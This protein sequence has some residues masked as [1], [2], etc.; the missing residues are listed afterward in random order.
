MHSLARPTQGAVTG[1]QTGLDLSSRM[2]RSRK[3]V[4][5]FVAYVTLKVAVKEL[6]TSIIANEMLS[7][8]IIYES[9]G[10]WRPGIHDRKI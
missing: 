6:I 7:F 5:Y 2:N 9:P 10:P 4:D 3:N 1:V 8:K